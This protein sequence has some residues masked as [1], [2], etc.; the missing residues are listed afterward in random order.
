MAGSWRASIG[1]VEPACC[2]PWSPVPS[3]VFCLSPSHYNLWVRE[4]Q[5]TQCAPVPAECGALIGIRLGGSWH[6][7]IALKQWPESISYGK[8]C[9]WLSRFASTSITFTFCILTPG[10]PSAD[11]M[12]LGG[13]GGGIWG[14]SRHYVNFSKPRSRYFA[15]RC[16]YF[17]GAYFS[18]MVMLKLLEI[19]YWLQCVYQ[20]TLT[21][22][23][24][25]MK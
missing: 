10:F 17:Y 18:A 24:V 9:C 14:K 3:D 1:T 25:R 16:E 15:H 6:D 23:E 20:L 7:G 13:K 22:S 2:I 21:L 8:L 11:H 19:S 5:M 12:S 4:R